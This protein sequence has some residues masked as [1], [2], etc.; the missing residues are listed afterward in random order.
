MRAHSRA[1]VQPHR[2]RYENISE[3]KQQNHFLTA[4]HNRGLAHFNV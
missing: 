4:G 3:R 2:L 1:Q